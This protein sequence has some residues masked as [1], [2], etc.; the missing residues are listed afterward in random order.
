MK[1][2][3]ALTGTASAAALALALSGCVANNPAGGD[4]LEVTITDDGC[5]V[6]AATASAGPIT[7]ALSNEGTQ[8]NEFEI[9]ADDKLRIVGE[10]ENIAPGQSVSYI[11]SLP[12][13]DYF[14]EC[15]LNMVGEGIGTAAFTVS[16][17]GGGVSAAD[18]EA[19]DQAVANY[20]SY[21]K[22]QVGELV[23]AVAEFTS[24]YREGDDDRARE[25][26]ATARTHYERIEPTAEAF[27]DLDPKIDFR[28]PMASEDGIAFTGF[29][30]IE[31]DLWAPDGFTPSDD[32]GRAELA[33]GLDANVQ[34]LYDLVYADD[35]TVSLADIS[36]G[37]IGLLDEVATSKIT[38]EEDEFSHTDLWDFQANVEGASVAYGNVKDIAIASGAEGEELTAEIDERFEQLNALLAQYGSLE[39]GFVLYTDLSTE[40]VKEL[41]D[42]INALAEPLSQLTHTVLGVPADGE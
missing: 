2:L 15:K 40:Q 29:H 14:T 33:D 12:A 9:L 36:N 28:E 1:K 4:A 27:G 38:G 42:G 16:G 37:A 18:Q 5:A 26:F 10:K 23:P 6:S 8:L 41:S 11:A 17:E 21:I 22:D 7:F 34:E 3:T 20:V 30:R 25:L 39:D 35:F 13:G 32:A 31:K 19:S 24:A